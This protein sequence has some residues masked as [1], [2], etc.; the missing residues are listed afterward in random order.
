MRYEVGPNDG[1][2]EVAIDGGAPVAIDA[3]QP[4]LF[5][6]KTTAI[7]SGLVHTVHH[8]VVTCVTTFCNVDDFPVTCP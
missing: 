4:G 6:M 2:I 3:H 1:R 5:A 8:A 7:A